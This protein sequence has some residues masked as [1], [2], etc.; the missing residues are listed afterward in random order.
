[1]SALL[2]T[3]IVWSI[4]SK[5]EDF[6]AHAQIR[7][8]E[9][10]VNTVGVIDTERS[11]VIGS[12]LQGDK[13]KIIDLVDDGI[14][15]KKGDL[16]VSFDKSVFEEEILTLSG[17]IEGMQ[18]ALDAK[19]EA[20]KWEKSQAEQ[21][22]RAAQFKLTKAEAD[23]LKLEKG[24]GPLQLADYEQAMI[25]AQQKY[26]NYRSY[27]DELHAL[28]ASGLDSSSEIQTARKD[29]KK[30][31]SLYDIASNR[32]K[33][34][35]DFVLPS[36]IEAAKSD[37]QKAK[38]EI[39]QV[40]KSAGFAIAKAIA[41]ARQAEREMLAA[42]KK[43]TLLQ[44]QVERTELR[45]PSDGIVVLVENFIAGERRKSRVGDQVWQNKPILY[46]PDISSFVVKTRIREVD[47]YKVRID[48]EVNITV[49]A[50]PGQYFTGHVTAIGALAE[51]GM[52]SQ[53]QK[54]FDLTVTLDETDRPLRPGMSAAVVIHSQKL[55]DI[56]TIP[57]QAVFS[58][59]TQH[60]VYKATIGGYRKTP[61]KTGAFDFRWVQINEGLS[62][63]DRVS[64]LEPGSD[65]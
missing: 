55:S 13:G 28:K 47:I 38:M 3:V 23:L 57:T 44:E 45:A 5:R 10:K 12:Q 18:A 36:D 14:V 33:A 42:K 8:L 2:L 31:E 46:L 40:K 56:L 41:T 16:L 50:F 32:F 59:G 49:D 30:F 34:Y 19:E 1:M 21:E 48:Q 15:V 37:V 20:V 53:Y 58:D 6:F 52:D 4:P 51:K 9:I 64:L 43:L 26:D 25:D 22:Y 61:V 65:Y 39:E 54:Y 62:D 7:D 35:R 63:G 27:M 60:W 24:D 29:L 11:L 17:A